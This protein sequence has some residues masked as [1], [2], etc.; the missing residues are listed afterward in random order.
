MIFP[1]LLSLPLTISPQPAHQSKSE[2][3]IH[4]LLNQLT[5]PEYRMHL[6]VPTTKKKYQQLD[7]KE[8]WRFNFWRERS[9]IVITVS[10]ISYLFSF[11]L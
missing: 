1:K 6:V 7:L 10:H 3:I 5:S 4:Y 2:S 11:I 9:C 8:S